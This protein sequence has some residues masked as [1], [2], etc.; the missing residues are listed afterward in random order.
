MAGRSKR[1]AKQYAAVYGGKRC[2][3]TL[4]TWA[5]VLGI[6]YTGIRNALAEG[7]T[8]EQALRLDGLNTANKFLRGGMMARRA[9]S[10]G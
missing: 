7:K 1:Q 3:Y 10:E 9:V 6:G 8:I 2:S 5:S 4:Q